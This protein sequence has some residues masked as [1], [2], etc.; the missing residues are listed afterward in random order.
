M[1]QKLLRLHLYHLVLTCSRHSALLDAGIPARGWHGEAYRGHIFW[2][3]IFVIPLLSLQ[4]PQVAKAALLYRYRRLNAARRYAREYGYKG[5]M[6]P[7]QSG[8]DGREETQIFH[9]NPV[10]G[11]WGPDHSSLQRHVSLAVAYNA[12][13]YSQISGDSDFLEKEGAEL[14]FEICRFW[15]SACRFN[16]QTGRY[17][18]E[19]VMGPDEFHERHPR[20]KDGGLSDNAYT[21]IMTAWLMRRALSSWKEMGEE[22]RNRLKEKIGFEEA[23]LEEWRKISQRLNLTVSSEGIIA[24]F[25][26][27]FELKELDWDHFRLKYGDTARMDRLLK[28]EGLSP[29]DYK[30]SKQADLLMAFYNLGRDETAEIIRSFGIEIAGD[31]LS[32]HLDYYLPRTSHGSTLS[33]VVHAVVGH[34]A[35]RRELAWRMYRKALISDFDDIQGGTT[36]EGIHAGVMAGTVWTALSTYAGLDLRGAIVSLKPCLPEGWDALGF[37]FQFKGQSYRVQVSKTDVKVC[38]EEGAERGAEI[39][40]CGR[41]YRLAKSSWLEVELCRVNS[42]NE[43]QEGVC[44]IANNLAE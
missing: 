27:Y 3:E 29:D 22:A 24:Q 39:H 34:S 37:G 33:R 23:E 35:A 44:Q 11:T 17:S 12:W 6:F 26:G 36:G 14:I 5:A 7:W 8:S 38:L 13:M 43:V 20:F 42:G 32:K 21:N 28:A 1:A 15:A 41:A 16:P 18:I 10:D 31:C 2:D 30:V 9:L 40:V 19:R 25:D 4:L